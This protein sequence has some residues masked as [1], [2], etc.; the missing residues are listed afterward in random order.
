MTLMSKVDNFLLRW[1]PLLLLRLTLLKV[2]GMMAM[3]KMQSA[4]NIPPV[5]RSTTNI[6]FERE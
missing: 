3:I 4:I 2:E 6:L 5:V 1:L